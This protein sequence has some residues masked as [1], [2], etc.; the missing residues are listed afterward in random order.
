M[1]RFVAA[2]IAGALLGFAGPRYQS[3]GWFSLIPWAIVGLALGYW[4]QR[5]ERLI[6]GALYGFSLC[7]SFMVAG[8][9]GVAPLTSR[10]PFFALIGVFGAVCG[11][12]LT[13]IGHALL[14][15]RRSYSP[16]QRRVIPGAHRLADE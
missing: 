6:T 11:L 15:R 16:S 12:V 13:L 9:S 5:S 14:A 2:V 10:L 4:S 7:F 8:Y 1:I 3:L